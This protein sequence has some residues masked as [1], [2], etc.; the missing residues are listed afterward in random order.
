MPHL[1][2]RVHRSLLIPGKAEQPRL[3][4][5]DACL[6]YGKQASLSEMEVLTRNSKR[7][8]QTEEGIECQTER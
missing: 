4:S 8:G 5:V 2:W 1:P 3:E 7:L 6:R